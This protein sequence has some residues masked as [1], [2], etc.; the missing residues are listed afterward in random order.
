MK[1]LAASLALLLAIACRDLPG[2][3][4]FGWPDDTAS[5]A[6][7]ADVAPDVADSADVAPSLCGNHTCDEDETIATCPGD[8][9][10]LFPHL[11]GACTHPGFADGCNAGYAC[12]HRTPGAGGDVCVANFPTWMPLD[13]SRS[14][15]DFTWDDET[16]TDTRTGLMWSQKSLFDMN[17]AT[18]M[19]ACPSQIWGGFA[20]WRLPTRAEIRSLVDYTKQQPANSAAHLDW[21]PLRM[22]YL[23]AIGSPELPDQDITLDWGRGDGGQDLM[24]APRAVRCVRGGTSGVQTVQRFI[25]SPDGATLLD[26]ALGRT[27]QATPATAP[28]NWSKA[29]AAC[30]QN[31]A[32]SPGVGWRLPT[33]REA[34]ALVEDRLGVNLPDGFAPTQVVEWTSTFL[35]GLPNTPWMASF[36]NTTPAGAMGNSATLQGVR[37]IR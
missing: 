27:W 32:H 18:A 10:G 20:D 4:G 21:D 15:S 8:C 17:F 33:V 28:K 11:A 6:D 29:N 16:V 35:Q 34:D 9:S 3:D 19:Q 7:A 12:V 22:R 13:V 37:C 30:L 36:Q 23:T 5:A 31:D 26:R 1:Q 14:A 25:A 2:R 24:A